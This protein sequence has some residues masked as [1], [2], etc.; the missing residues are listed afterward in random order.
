MA[1]VSFPLLFTVGHRVFQPGATN[2]HGDPVESWAPAVDR[3]VYGW[4]SPDTSEPKLAGHDRDVVEVEL[5]VPS[6]FSCGP[7]DRMVLDGVVFEVIG[8]PEMSDHNPF[9]WN[10]GGVVNLRKVS[11]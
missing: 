10:P 3:K 5:L 9:G 8:E 11:G 4:S 2:A 7:R 6:G 1:G